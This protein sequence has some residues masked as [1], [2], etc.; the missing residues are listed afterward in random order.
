MPDKCSDPPAS[1]PVVNV[2]DKGAKGDGKTDDTASIQAAIDAVGGTKGTV[3]VPDG[4]YLIE[5]VGKKPLSLKSDMTLKLAP[6]AVLKAKPNNSTHYILL[7]VGNVSN[8]WVV[9]G[10]LLGERDR[11][12][13]K[14]GQWGF[15]IAIRKGAKA[16][17][18]IGV[19]SRDMWGDGFYV[20][21]AKDVRLCSVTADHNRRQGLSIIHAE[22]VLVSDSVFKNTRGTKP[23]AGI[24]L[25]PDE[26]SQEIA[27]VRIENS[28]FLNNAGAGVIVSGRNAS[29][30]SVAMARNTF[31]GNYRPIVVSNA[32]AVGGAICG[33]RQI[34]QQAP[35]SEGFGNSYAE[36]VANV[37]TQDECGDPAL[38]LKR[39]SK[40]KK[41][42]N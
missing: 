23:S 11:H 28:K 15:G 21:D 38:I 2:R 27:N 6:K 22:G 3:F 19:T 32:P 30:A 10:T 17:T 26:A 33:N 34:T 25:E 36:P 18:I 29:I 24:D 42:K 39:Q 4:V 5:A 1:G 9:G 20:Q 8:V 16:V 31:E 35:P 37:V 13:G 7:Q 12:T 14:G 41:K 40:K